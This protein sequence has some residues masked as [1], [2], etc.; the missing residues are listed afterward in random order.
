MAAC[1]ATKLRIGNEPINQRIGG[2]EFVACTLGHVPVTN[3]LM[4]AFIVVADNP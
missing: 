2:Q 3:R 1:E 4:D